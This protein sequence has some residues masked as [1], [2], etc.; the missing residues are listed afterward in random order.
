MYMYDIC[1]SVWRECLYH[2]LDVDSTGIIVT[3]QGMSDGVYVFTD[4]S[5]IF[6]QALLIQFE[7]FLLKNFQEVREQSTVYMSSVVCTI[8]GSGSSPEIFFVF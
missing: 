2:I 5:W 4:E 8:P 6:Y 3:K 7:N 1:M